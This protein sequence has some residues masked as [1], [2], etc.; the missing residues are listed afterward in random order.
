MI[1]GMFLWDEI[2]R[3][4]Y[5]NFT[6]TH[7]QH[8]SMQANLATGFSQKE[9]YGHIQMKNKKTKTKMIVSANGHNENK[10]Q[11]NKCL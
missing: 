6:C 8:S 11:F 1:A 7:A 10:K 3:V 9:N 5:A 4:T 2:Y